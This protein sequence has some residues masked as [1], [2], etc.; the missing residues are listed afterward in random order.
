MQP[1]Y[2]GRSSS[3]VPIAT[4]IDLSPLLSLLLA[5]LPCPHPLFLIFDLPVQMCSTFSFVP[6]YRGIVV[7]F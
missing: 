5:F 7:G 2:M 1:W 6:A 4:M 3:S